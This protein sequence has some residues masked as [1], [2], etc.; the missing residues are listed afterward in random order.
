MYT[1]Y[2]RILVVSAFFG[3]L[4]S[5][6]LAYSQAN[7]YKIHSLFIYNFTKHVQ[8][9]D[10]VGDTFTIGVYGNSKALS[11]VKKN[12]TGKKFS[13]KEIRVINIAGLGDVKTS[14]LVYFPKSNKNKI[15]NL[16][17]EVDKSNTLFVSEDDLIEYG[18]PISFF[19]KNN[20]LAFKVS[21][22]N[23]DALGLK[24]SSSLLSLADVVD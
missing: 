16:F 7:I 15:L 21:K 11:E 9:S 10:D 19:L 2:L 20:K 14:D 13:E 18:I 22:N 23:L 1:K 3:G 8:W 12:F 5:Q 24:I 6:N 4:I 17:D